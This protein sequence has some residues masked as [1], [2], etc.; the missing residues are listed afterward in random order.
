MLVVSKL[1][2]RDIALE[3]VIMVNWVQGTG[4]I[5]LT[6]KSHVLSQEVLNGPR[7]LLG[8]TIRVA[9]TLLERHIAGA[10]TQT[11]KMGMEKREVSIQT[12]LLLLE[13]SNLQRSNGRMLSLA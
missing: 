4:M 2:E 7:Y 3:K 13:E 11:G 5:A 12:P 1:M 10:K 8:N 6:G 9:S